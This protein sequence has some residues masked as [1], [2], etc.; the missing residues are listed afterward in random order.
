MSVFFVKGEYTVQTDNLSYVVLDG[1][2]NITLAGE[3]NVTIMCGN[4][5]QGL[6]FRNSNIANI[7][8]LKISDCC[9]D[10]NGVVLKFTN[11]T[12]INIGSV[13]IDNTNCGTAI[14]VYN[15][16]SL[17]VYSSNLMLLQPYLMQIKDTDDILIT[18]STFSYSEIAVTIKYTEPNEHIDVRRVSVKHCSFINNTLGGLYIYNNYHYINTTSVIKYHILLQH[19]VFTNSGVVG[20]YIGGA[21]ILI[22]TPIEMYV[23]DCIFVS[24]IGGGMTIILPV[25]NSR[26]KCTII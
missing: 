18:N 9:M 6:W 16:K 2:N 19:S 17:Y 11:V 14:S 5:S 3:N 22:Y 15:A 24:N 1:A 21:F 13:I 8:S 23:L 12:Q 25:E 7:N 20:S 26:P 10:N 4:T